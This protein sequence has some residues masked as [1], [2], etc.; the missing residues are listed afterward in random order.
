MKGG[1]RAADLGFLLRVS[2]PL[3]R[4]QAQPCVDMAALSYY[5]KRLRALG[6]GVGCVVNSSPTRSS[7]S[8]RTGALFAGTSSSAVPG[9]RA[10]SASSAFGSTGGTSCGA[11]SVH[12][13]D[14]AGVHTDP[15]C[16]VPRESVRKESTKSV[17]VVG[18]STVLNRFGGACSTPSTSN[19][20]S[21]S[22]LVSGKPIDDTAI[23]MVP[24]IPCFG[25]RLLDLPP[26]TCCAVLELLTPCDL[27]RLGIVAKALRWLPRDN[28]LWYQLT[29][30][31]FPGFSN[32][33]T[34]IAS[35][36]NWEEEY[37]Y[38]LRMELRSRKFMMAQM[39]GRLGRLPPVPKRRNRK[40]VNYF[41][42]NNLNRC[43]AG[44]VSASGD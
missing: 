26:D 41:R 38:L 43:C 6:V 7:A 8:A 5:E 1:G 17:L 28:W 37:Q 22:V 32:G 3:H 29:V 21:A 13:A 33:T 4:L 11:S 14:G 30:R 31:H 23:N 25:F 2:P 27:G 39:Q 15:A 9:A 18:G 12:A 24:G 40:P 35:R 16:R 42:A 34:T 19:S 44:L 36:V 20:N 10:G